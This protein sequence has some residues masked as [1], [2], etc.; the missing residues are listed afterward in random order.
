M[1]RKDFTRGIPTDLSPSRRQHTRTLLARAFG[2]LVHSL[3]SCDRS[4]P[5]W[6]N[7]TNAR[8]NNRAGGYV[9]ALAL[10]TGKK[11]AMI[12]TKW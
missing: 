9:A 11:P 8:D 7:Y 1:N 2:K 5:I 4:P 3:A 6:H 10:E 12:I